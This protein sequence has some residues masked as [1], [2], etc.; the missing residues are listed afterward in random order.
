MAKARG[1]MSKS[2]KVA[3]LETISRKLARKKPRSSQHSCECRN[4]NMKKKP[5]KT[6][7]SRKR[8][9]ASTTTTNKKRC[10]TTTTKKRRTRKT[11]R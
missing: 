8:K 3:S 5:R 4:K 11:K 1:S 6:C 9:A 2:T 10:S 7:K